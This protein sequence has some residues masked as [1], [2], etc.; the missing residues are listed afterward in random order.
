MQIRNKQ[1][2][3]T[4]FFILVVDDTAKE[5]WSLQSNTNDSD[6]KWHQELPKGPMTTNKG[7]Y[8]L[9]KDSADIHRCYPTPFLNLSLAFTELGWKI[10]I[11]LKHS[12][13]LDFSVLWDPE[14]GVKSLKPK[15]SR[16]SKGLS[17]QQIL[18]LRIRTVYFPH[19]LGQ[20]LAHSSCLISIS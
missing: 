8:R 13:S 14:L 4:L 9:Y 19:H 15:C 2:A 18:S 10:E 3:W 6:S 12:F 1:K 16:T 17:D 5:N 7:G 11:W 20:C